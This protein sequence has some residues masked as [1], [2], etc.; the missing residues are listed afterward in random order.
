MTA[1]T[2]EQQGELAK[3]PE[4][5]RRLVDA[6]LAAGNQIAEVGHSF[7]A[8]PVGAYVRLAKKVTTRLR[9][10]DETI[11]FYERHG[12]AYS[13]EFT[14]AQRFYFVLEPPE[15]YDMDAIRSSLQPHPHSVQ[16]HPLNPSIPTILSPLPSKSQS[17]PRREKRD[18]V[19]D[20]VP[21]PLLTGSPKSDVVSVDESQG[22]ATRSVYFQDRGSPFEVQRKLERTLMTLFFP[23]REE[24]KLCLRAE[25][26]IVGARYRFLLRYEAAF[27]ESNLYWLQM[28]V[29]WAPGT[30]E[31]HE[32]YRKTSAS[33]FAYW[34]ESFVTCE[35]PSA[36]GNSTLYERRRAE[37]INAERHLDSVASI[38]QS[39]LT[40]MKGG[41][42]F[43]SSHKEGDTRIYWRE[44][45]FLRSDSGD[46]PLEQSFQDELEFLNKL[47]QF[48]HW[49]VTRNSDKDRL[50]EFDIWRLIYRQMHLH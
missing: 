21:D 33:W 48:L 22:S 13:G 20:A 23:S 50:S 31:Q 44:G 29:D 40:A 17:D 28:V 35:F 32:Y 37:S 39:I 45:R 7:P 2:I 1:L 16:P 18:R 47:Y 19:R 36:I 6:E 8:P 9:A 5:L 24:S 15:V 4:V 3:F 49:N 11:Q 46:D 12:S 38:Q 34:T 27:E 42:T 14:D 10:S 30:M 25:A 43:R 41:A 26:S